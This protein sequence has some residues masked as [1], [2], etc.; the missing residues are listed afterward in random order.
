[1]FWGS[2]GV[3]RA[4]ASAELEVLERL[5][6]ATTR[7]PHV[8]PELAAGRLEQVRRAPAHSAMNGRPS[9]SASS[10]SPRI[11]SV[12]D[13]SSRPESARAGR[14]RTARRS[15]RPRREARST[16]S[17]SVEVEHDGRGCSERRRPSASSCARPISIARSRSVRPLV[18]PENSFAV[19]IVVSAWT[20]RSTR[21]RLL[22]DRQR[23]ARRADLPSRT[24]R[25]AS[26]G[27]PTTPR[28]RARWKTARP[29]R[30]AP[31][32]SSR[33]EKTR[34][35]SPRNQAIR[36]SSASASAPRCSVSSARESASRASSSAAAASRSSPALKS[37]SARLNS[38]S[39]TRRRLRPRQVE[40]ARVVAGR[41]R[42]RVER[43]LRGRRRAR[44][45]V[46]RAAS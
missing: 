36:A 22:G 25:P 24:R 44:W 2:D 46:G 21:S 33:C 17:R 29:R 35:C 1:M 39:G 30:S 37:A 5:V 12:A 20:R 3:S 7:E 18:S 45:L 9:R 15:R 6:R 41:G 43:R 31:R 34:S 42:E 16:R 40:R 26:A 10:Q 13:T 4:S 28:T 23:L 27:G 32:P 19:P 11:Q 38:R 8:A 14:R